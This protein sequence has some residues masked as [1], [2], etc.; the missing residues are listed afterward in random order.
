MAATARWCEV[1]KQRV[2]G[3]NLGQ[4]PVLHLYRLNGDSSAKNTRAPPQMRG[5]DPWWM[6]KGSV[7]VCVCVHTHEVV[8]ES[9]CAVGRLAGQSVG[10]RSHLNL[11]RRQ[12]I[13]FQ[14]GH[15]HFLQRR[16]KKNPTSAAMKST[17]GREPQK[18]HIAALSLA[19]LE[20]PNTWRGCNKG[21]RRREQNNGECVDLGK[22]SEDMRATHCSARSQVWA[23]KHATGVWMDRFRHKGPRTQGCA[24]L[25]SA[26]I[27]SVAFST[28]Q[29][30]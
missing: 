27:M 5:H 17:W 12:L 22:L 29:G 4:Q 8:R 11:Y 6:N 7:C 18:T 30:R 16:G 13:Y 2:G 24:T 3:L 10:G 21:E 14:Q 20:L 9:I 15:G 23:C 1:C 28:S 19:R 26:S 25:C